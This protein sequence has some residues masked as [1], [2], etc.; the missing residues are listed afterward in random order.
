MAIPSNRCR[1]SCPGD[2]PLQVDHGSRSWISLTHWGTFRP[3]AP[4]TLAIIDR[5]APQARRA[6]STAMSGKS[7]S[8]LSRGGVQGGVRPHFGADQPITAHAGLTVHCRVAGN[9]KGVFS[10]RHE[11]S[12]KCTERHGCFLLSLNIDFKNV[13][14]DR[15]D[16]QRSTVDWGFMLE[17]HPRLRAGPFPPT[18]GSVPPT[19]GSVPRGRQRIKKYEA[20]PKAESQ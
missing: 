15:K 19:G 17:T 10:L 7:S 4:Q 14:A 2:I 8:R 3:A 12:A 18:A 11:P 1:S 13:E 16:A 6:S 20:K 5:T 9:Q